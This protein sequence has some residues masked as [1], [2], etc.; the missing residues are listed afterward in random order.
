MYA[1]EVQVIKVQAELFKSSLEW[2]KKDVQEISSVCHHGGKLGKDW[3]NGLGDTRVCVCVRVCLCVFYSSFREK[4]AGA[5]LDEAVK[6][7]EVRSQLCLSACVSQSSWSCGLCIIDS[8]GHRNTPPLHPAPPSPPLFPK[9]ASA[10]ALRQ[11]CGL[12]INN[13]FSSWMLWQLPNLQLF[14]SY[15]HLVSR[16]YPWHFASFNLKPPNYK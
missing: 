15:F 13:F 14:P 1:N 11:A 12:L 3:I 16:C 2:N 8:E 5:K 10:H 4:V 7:L 9:R 6:A